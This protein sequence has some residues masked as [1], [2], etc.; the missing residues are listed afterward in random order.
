MVVG[1]GEGEAALVAQ[2]GELPPVGAGV[3]VVA[4]GLERVLRAELLVAHVALQHL[5]HPLL[6]ELLDPLLCLR[7]PALQVG[8]FL[9]VFLVLLLLVRGSSSSPR[10][11]AKTGRRQKMEAMSGV[12]LGKSIIR[13]LTVSIKEQNFKKSSTKN[14]IFL[15]DPR[16]GF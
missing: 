9:V 16:R 12:T 1:A 2:L 6:L 14:K 7:Q 11:A 13:S 10:S 8:H 5:V 3:L 4:V 15:Y